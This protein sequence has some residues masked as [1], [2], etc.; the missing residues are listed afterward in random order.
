MNL[1]ENWITQLRYYADNFGISNYTYYFPIGA[2]LG[3]VI[4]FSFHHYFF[5]VK[6][7]TVTDNLIRSAFF[8][9]LITTILLLTVV[10]ILKRFTEFF[11]LEKCELIILLILLFL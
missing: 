4:L 7:R 9:S 11:S 5:K 1:N 2:I 8:G 6:E 3:F 10:F